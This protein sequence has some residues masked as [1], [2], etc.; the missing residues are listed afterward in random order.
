MS[1][2]RS[3]PAVLYAAK[4]TEDK[5]ASIPDQLD[6]GR[7]LAEGE[8]WKVA[9]EFSDENF[10][11]YSRN[12][13][14]DLE[15]AKTLALKLAAEEG[16]CHLV[17]LHSDRV[18]RGAGDAPDSADHLVEVVATLRRHNVTL[19]TVEDDFF[20]D[21]RIG[22]MMAA[23]QGQR[24]SEDSR[25]KSAA[26]RAGMK[27]SQKRGVYVG[28][29]A[30]GLAWRRDENDERLPY[31]LPEAIPII[32]RIFSEYLKGVGQL[33]IAQRL[34][35]DGIPTARKGR[36]HQATVRTLLSAPVYAGLVNDG[37]K[38][39]EGR[40]EGIIDRDTW[41]K[42]QALRKAYA[43][44]KG[45]GRPSA[46]LHIFRKGFLKCGTCGGSMVPRTYEN[47]TAGSVR[48]IYYCYGRKVEPSQCATP[49]IPRTEIDLA[50]LSYFEQVGLDL[51]ATRNQL[52]AAVDQRAD[53]L[54][55]LH[56]AALTE[57]Q[58]TS[59]SL[60]R[61]KRDYMKGEISASEWHEIRDELAPQSEAAEAAA[62]RL[63]DQLAEV[64]G[65]L[66]E[67]EQEVIEHLAAV[68]AAVAG[69][70][71]DAGSVAEVR[72]ALSRL[73]DHFVVH[74][75]TPDSAHVELVGERWIEPV[76]SRLT[77]VGYDEQ[78]APVLSDASSEAENNYANGLVR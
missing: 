5:K 43:R 57:A 39:I 10:S 25:R 73:F 30:Y 66:A 41:E 78:I 75:G 61:V 53:E 52:T 23:V 54:R 22:L 68:R 1:Q 62:A 7:D 32:R 16:H 47:R 49:E 14:P 74:L 8:G 26:V 65:P 51:E 77:V 18:A 59:A 2:N 48:E 70:V 46:G 45:A 42:V 58:E 63:G 35:A 64:G 55:A 33:T 56:A 12:R 69:E 17:A 72:A 11:A 31:F 15:K 13:G 20:A 4:S 3:V 37:E 36:W 19:R 50:V 44:T 28:G 21:D 60:I 6:R 38:L 40:H 27:R 71:K 29:K 67:V 34:N 76:P 24:N 9:G